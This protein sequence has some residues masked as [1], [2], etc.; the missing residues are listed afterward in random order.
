M[1]RTDQRKSGV[2]QGSVQGFQRICCEWAFIVVRDKL[3]P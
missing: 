3:D 1:V 2:D